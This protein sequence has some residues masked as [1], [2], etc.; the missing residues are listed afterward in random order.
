MKSEKIAMIA[1]GK[2]QRAAIEGKVAMKTRPMAAKAADLVATDM[3]V[4]TIVGAPSYTSGVHIWKGAA[5][6]LNARPTA[7]KP[8]PSSSRTFP[9][10]LLP[11]APVKAAMPRKVVAPVAP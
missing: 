1:S 10:A 8:M 3:N 5:E 9:A 2:Y 11:A 6:A 7:R 4:V